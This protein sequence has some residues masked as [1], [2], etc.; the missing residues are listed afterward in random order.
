[1]VSRGYDGTVKLN[2]GNQFKLRDFVALAIVI[3]V[4]II[5]FLT[6]KGAK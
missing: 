1:M 3:I 5:F 6:A 2:S 4:G